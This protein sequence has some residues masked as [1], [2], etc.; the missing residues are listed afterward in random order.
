MIRTNSLSLN[1]IKDLAYNVR[2]QFGILPFECFPI[3]DYLDH[4]FEQGLLSIQV[5]DNDDPYLDNK[6]PAIYN[7]VD[8]FIYIKE[9]VLEEYDNNDYRANF[10]LAHELFHYL[11]A[12]VL[13]FEFK[14]VEYCFPY[15][16]IDWQANQ[17]AGELLVPEDSLV[18]DDDELVK[19]YKVSLECVLTRKVQLKNRQRRKHR[20]SI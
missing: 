17:F 10:T 6:T 1:D 8:N 11:Q 14:E 19:K 12:Q 15:E 4:L 2:K 9:E 16:D 5:I 13:N 7:T 3:L 18:L 20:F